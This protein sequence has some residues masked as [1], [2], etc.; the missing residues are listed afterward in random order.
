M[1]EEYDK[2]IEGQDLDPVIVD[3]KAD[4]EAALE[5][6]KDFEPS[7]GLHKAALSVLM[8]VAGSVAKSIL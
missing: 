5:Q 6:L 4:I 7:S 8:K 1:S 3:M 2:L